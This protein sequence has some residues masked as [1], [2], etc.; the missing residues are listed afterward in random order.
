MTVNYYGGPGGAT[1]LGWNWLN[2]IGVAGWHVAAAGHFNGDGT[3]DLIWQND[4]TR[5]VTVHYY[6]GAGGA[7]DL[8]WNWLN[9]ASVP[10][11]SVKAATDVN[12][13]GT[14]DLVWQNDTTSQVTVNYYGAPE[15]RSI[16]AG[17]G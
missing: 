10:G 6:G 12:R 7:T 11:W 17:T 15:A 14:P 9:S 13:D 16:K 5:Q 4:A 8:S 1:I 3:P 2:S